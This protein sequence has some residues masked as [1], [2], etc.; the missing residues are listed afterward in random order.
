MPYK[1]EISR[2]NPSAFL[3]LVDQS[4]SMQEPFGTGEKKT[5]KAIVVADT[6]NNLLQ[7]L[8]SKC[9]KSEG[10]RDYYYVGVIGYG[11]TTARP[12]LGGHLAQKGLVP[13]SLV[14]NSPIRIE[15]RIK[16][17]NDGRGNL[18][19]RKYQAPIWFEPTAGGGTPMCA[20]LNLANDILKPWVREHP[21]CFPPMVINISDGESSDGNPQK[22][23][24]D[25]TSMA[26]SDGN[27]L[28]FNLHIS[29][30]ETKAV[31]YPDNDRE[32]EDG[33][34]RDLFSISSHLTSYMRKVLSDE[35]YQISE[36]S[37]G[38]VFN[39]DFSALVKFID[40]GT[41]PSNLR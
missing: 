34:A 23:A 11:G 6:I 19:E 36:N 25:L 9:T 32:F 26:S 1:A 18:I 27:L 12:A 17:I 14:G 28:L 37:R 16:Q 35:G 8:V 30:H 40:I 3:F 22:A 41:R 24:Q 20:A 38:F 39:A 5:T 29:S 4:Q 13:I 21:Y 15:Q 2:A 31:E 33:Y 7:N 10:I